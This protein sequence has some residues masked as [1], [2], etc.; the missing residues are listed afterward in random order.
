MKTRLCIRWALT[1]VALMLL[2]SGLLQG[3]RAVPHATIAESLAF[4]GSDSEPRSEY[5]LGRLLV[6]FKGTPSVELLERYNLT[7]AERL[8]GLLTSSIESQS[9]IPPSETFIVTFDREKNPP[10]I[11]AEL[12]GDEWVAYAEPDYLYRSQMQPNDPL[13]NAPA[14][15]DGQWAPKRIGLELVWAEKSRVDTVIVNIDSGVQLDHPDLV[16]NLWRNPGEIAG[17]GRDD[18]GNGFIDD[19]YDWNF[20]DNNNNVSDTYGHGTGISGI[21]AVGNNGVGV[22]GASWGCQ[23]MSLKVVHGDGT[24]ATSDIIKAVS[25]AENTLSRQG[26]RGVFNASLAGPDR[27]Q[28]LG[29]VIKN[30][31]MLLVAATGNYGN[32]NPNDVFYPAAFN[33]EL[34]NVLSVTASTY[35]SD[36]RLLSGASW[37]GADLAAPGAWIMTTQ[38][39]SQYAHVGG[40]SLAA[41][42]V[43]HVLAMMLDLTGDVLAA[44]ARVLKSVDVLPTLAGKVKTG[45]R[46]N[47]DRAFHGRFNPNNP[48]V[49][50]AT[51]SSLSTG[52]G[53]LVS[54]GVVASDPDGDSLTASWDFGDGGHADGMSVAH[55]YQSLGA[56]VASATVSDGVASVSV[57]ISVTV[58]D[59]LTIGRVKLKGYDSVAGTAN[60]LTVF[61]TDSR[62]AQAPRPALTIVGVGEMTYDDDS[63]AYF[64]AK[65]RLNNIPSTLTIRSSLGG[66]TTRPWQ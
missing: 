17:N 12:N 57:N 44:K 38:M 48:P 52:E 35:D 18:D 49:A 62:Q 19:V 36:D 23:M 2:T 14:F 31:G 20:V 24:A 56:Y 40:T 63:Q 11:A 42:Y 58:T 37:L 6:K 46:L 51:R 33:S 30:S 61:A 7:L 50:T 8:D 5:M 32:T 55:V 28:A 41:P 59:A 4:Q 16:A 47:V 9:A 43:A 15:Q 45:G 66:E 54:L 60:K 21:G 1:A 3:L 65:K 10:E 26:K 27:S 39:G 22:A 34:L 53:Q 13:Y 64:L 29:D 25:Y